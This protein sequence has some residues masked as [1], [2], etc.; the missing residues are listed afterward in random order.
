[1]K[2]K[3]LIDKNGRTAPARSQSPT[4]SLPLNILSV[5]INNDIASVVLNDGPWTLERYLVLVDKKWYVAGI[6]GLVFHP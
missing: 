5:N 6:K 2:K 4:R 1:M 3:S